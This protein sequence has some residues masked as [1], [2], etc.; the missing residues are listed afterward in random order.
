MKVK[1]KNQ[2]SIEFSATFSLQSEEYDV[3]ALVWDQ[4]TP[5]IPAQS[6]TELGK[7]RIPE[8]LKPGSNALLWIDISPADGNLSSQSLSLKIR[9]AG[10]VVSSQLY[11]SLSSN[12]YGG[13][14]PEQEWH[15]GNAVV[16]LSN[17]LALLNF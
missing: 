12:P 15:A 2:T 4:R 9:F 8:N 16:R 5:V 7:I 3:S 10:G 6:K 1:I 11:H 17:Y 14:R 13:L